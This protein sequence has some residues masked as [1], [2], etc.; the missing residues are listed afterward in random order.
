METKE[1]GASKKEKKKKPSYFFWGSIFVWGNDATA[2]HKVHKTR[3]FPPWKDEA[4]GASANSFIHRK[5]VSRR[6]R[7]REKKSIFPFGPSGYG[8]LKENPTIFSR[9]K[10]DLVVTKLVD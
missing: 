7:R 3:L 4:V 8:R 2:S 1:V 10:T 6:G 5:S 9:S